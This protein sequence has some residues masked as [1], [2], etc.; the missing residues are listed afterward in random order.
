[1][2]ATAAVWTTVEESRD[3]APSLDDRS[4][5]A[6]N[7]RLAPRRGSLRHS[8]A[9]RMVRLARSGATAGQ[10]SRS[11]APERSPGIIGP[12]T[13][14]PGAG[15]VAADDGGAWPCPRQLQDPTRP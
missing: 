3:I 7:R 9:H 12:Q 5:G 14:K 13:D 8:L 4:I 11:V 2:H 6:R 15:R 10:A 1:M